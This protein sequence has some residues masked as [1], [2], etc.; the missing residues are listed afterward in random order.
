MKKRK[1]SRTKLFSFVLLGVGVVFLVFYYQAILIGAGRFLAPEGVGRADVVI[2][3]GTELIREKAIDTG[4]GLLSTGR[5]HRLVLV[6]QKSEDEMIF[7]RPLDYNLFLGQKLEELGLRKD[8]F[9]MLEVPKK[10]PITLVE[11]KCVLSNLSKNG[12]RSAILLSED[13]H[14]RRSYWTYKQVGIPLGIEIIPCPYFMTYRN[15]TWWQQANGI[16]NFIGE[17]LK[18]FYYLLRGYIPLKSLL[19]A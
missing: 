12:A 19:F 15:D 7:G 2:L 9:Q 11:A 6:Y 4:K 13:F 14:T 5:A 10:H 16:R 17:S 18:F 8:Q 3:E 1:I